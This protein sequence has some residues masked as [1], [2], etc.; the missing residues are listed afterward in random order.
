MKEPI[1]LPP[2]HIDE[3]TTFKVEADHELTQALRRYRD[4]YRNAYGGD[5]TEADLLR[6]MARRFMADDKGFQTYCK[7]KRR[8]KRSKVPRVGSRS[9]PSPSH[10]PLRSE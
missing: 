1:A 3:I 4:Y 2:F 7:K 6:E 8:T 10:L 9:T 5:V